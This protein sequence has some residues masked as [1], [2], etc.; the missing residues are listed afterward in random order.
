MLRAA[1]I[2]VVS[3]VLVIAAPALAAAAPAHPAQEDPRGSGAIWLAY[4]VFVV[5]NLAVASGATRRFGRG[6]FRPGRSKLIGRC[7]AAQP[8]RSR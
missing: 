8:L 6:G 4:S 2:L 3:A 5:A 1:R 7:G